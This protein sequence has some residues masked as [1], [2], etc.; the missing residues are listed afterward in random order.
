MN[1]SVSL[2]SGMRSLESQ[3][4]TFW[5]EEG[6][7]GAQATLGEEESAGRQA[8]NSFTQSTC[9]WVVWKGAEALALF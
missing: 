5:L 9:S 3:G 7:V 2:S 6:K 1:E 8:G 4:P